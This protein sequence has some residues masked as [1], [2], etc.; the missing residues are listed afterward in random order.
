MKTFPVLIQDTRFENSYYLGGVY[1]SSLEDANYH[2]GNM[3]G[4]KVIRLITEIPELTGEREHTLRYE[5]LF[6]C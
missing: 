1:C 6:T 4:R 3:P 2:Y 5:D